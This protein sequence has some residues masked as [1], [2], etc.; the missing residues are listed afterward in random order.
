MPARSIVPPVCPLPAYWRGVPANR[1]SS[2]PSVTSWPLCTSTVDV[3][4][5]GPVGP[6]AAGISLLAAVTLSGGPT[7]LVMECTTDDLSVT[8]TDIQLMAI[9]VGAVTP[10]I[11]P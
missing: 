7:D 6:G 8:A 9:Q 5:T 2:R 11:A 4:A 3:P 1:N 10:T